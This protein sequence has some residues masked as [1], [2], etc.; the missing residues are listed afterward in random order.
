MTTLEEIELDFIQDWR[1]GKTPTLEAYAQKYP[2]HAAALVDFVLEFV[3]M[4]NALA[5]TPQ[6]KMPSDEVERIRRR[7]LESI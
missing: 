4:E 3:A 1:D 2:E 5:R 7:V 6:P